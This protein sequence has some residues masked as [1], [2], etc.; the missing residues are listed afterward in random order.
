MDQFVKRAAVDVSPAAAKSEGKTG[1]SEVEIIEQLRTEGRLAWALRLDGREKSAKNASIN[2]IY[3]M[4]P[5]GFEGKPA[6]EKIGT[7][8]KRVIFYSA[9][10]SRWKILD[11]LADSGNGLSYA[12]TED[13]GQMAPLNLPW[14]VFNGSSEGY[15]VDPKVTCVLLSGTEESQPAS[16]GTGTTQ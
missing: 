10:K 7:E 13:E 1:L 8:S 4:I 2:G 6:Y 14:H 15:L 3:A 16:A 9:R 11:K 5:G 12:K